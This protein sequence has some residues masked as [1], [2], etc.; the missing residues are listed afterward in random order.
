MGRLDGKNAIVTGGG[1]GI[2]QACA[3]KLASEGASILVSDIRDTLASETVDRITD[4]GAT[5]YAIHC[6]VGDEDQVEAMTHKAVEYF[7]SVDILITSAGVTTIGGIHD[8]SLSD[9]ERVL[10]IN[11]TGTFLCARAALKYMIQKKGGTI[12]TI[13]SVSSIV[14][15]GESSACYKASKA[16]VLQ[17]TRAIATE[18]AHQGVRANCICP[19]GAATNMGQHR[20][21]EATDATT[22]ITQEP[23]KYNI[24]I[25]MHRRAD[26][27]EIANVAAFLASEE[28][29][30]MTG[31]AVMVDGGYTAV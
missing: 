10:R 11:L 1:S 29:S 4:S 30:F 14:T 17:L 23:R 7:G 26:P 6:D 27:M 21:E 15:G 24:D 19:G 31:S 18:Y 9:W 16:G 13:G 12:I 25:P 22:Q 2:G 20:R 5:A 3:C 8:L 28:A